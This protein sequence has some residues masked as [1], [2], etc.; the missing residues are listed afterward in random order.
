VRRQHAL[1]NRDQAVAGLDFDIDR[2]PGATAGPAVP[3]LRALELS[4]VAREHV[5]V[6]TRSG[7]IV[8]Q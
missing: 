3:R 1:A 5:S 4:S 6:I 8:E 2:R 7:Q